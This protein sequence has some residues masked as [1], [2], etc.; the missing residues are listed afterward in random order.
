MIIGSEVMTISFYKGLT[1]NLEI[2][3][4]SLSFAQYQETGASKEYQIWHERI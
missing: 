4:T 1:R 3:N 2:G